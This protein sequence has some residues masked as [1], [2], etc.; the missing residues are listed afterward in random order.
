MLPPVAVNCTL[1]PK[2][3]P[4]EPPALNT[5]ELAEITMLLEMLIALPVKVRSPANDNPEEVDMVP[6]AVTFNVFTFWKAPSAMLALPL[7][8]TTL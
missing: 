3:M 1:E 2:V 6:A 7:L 8:S 5:I 4:L